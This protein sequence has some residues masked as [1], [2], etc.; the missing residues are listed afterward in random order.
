M[1][2]SLSL[3]DRLLSVGETRLTVDLLEQLLGL[4]KSQLIFDLIAAVGNGDVKSVLA[5]TDSIIANGLAVDTLIVSLIDHLRN[6]MLLRACGSDSQL[7]EVPGLSLK[8]LTAQAEKFDPAALSQDIVILEELRRH[9]RQSQAGRALLDA[10]MVRM[11]LSD[12]FSSLSDLLARATGG[13]TA[14]AQKKKLTENAAV[15]ARSNSDEHR[16]PNIEH[17]TPN[18]DVA[19]AVAPAVPNLTAESK[20]P[21]FNSPPVSAPALMAA[22]LDD[23]DDLPAPG[24]VWDGPSESL[25]T[26]MAK[27]TAATAVSQVTPQSTSMVAEPSNVE[28]IRTADLGEKWR[29]MLKLI[30][31][32]GANSGLSGLL[33]HGQFIGIEDGQAVIRYAP[34]HETFLKMFDRNGKK[35]V[36]RDALSKVIEQPIGVRF[37]IGGPAAGASALAP[38]TASTTNAPPTARAAEPAPRPSAPPPPPVPP[39]DAANTIRITEE[40]RATLYKNDAL[41]RAVVDTLGGSVIRLEEQV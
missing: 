20:A 26:L 22:D 25:A 32:Q 16:T 5:Q 33:Q 37:E 7:V 35:D 31:D 9:V 23:D 19:V 4:P 40:L 14:A 18:E 15:S 24:K 28:P 36:V 13:G 38:A 21:E 29:A 1:R 8:E 30:A 6:L 3:L 17:R 41:I 10:T 11:T 2:D 12:Q 34:Q 27:H 39:V